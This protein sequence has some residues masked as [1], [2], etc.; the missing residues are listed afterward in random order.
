MGIEVGVG[1]EY[2]G[3]M[4]INMQREGETCTYKEKRLDSTAVKSPVCIAKPVICDILETTTSF[5]YSPLT[6][7]ESL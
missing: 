4:S 2:N 6:Y 1:E 7:N 3:S 5:L